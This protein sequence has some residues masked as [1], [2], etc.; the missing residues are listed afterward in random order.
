M[1]QSTTYILDMVITK[2]KEQRECMRCELLQKLESV[3]DEL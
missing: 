2:K 1:K 3:L